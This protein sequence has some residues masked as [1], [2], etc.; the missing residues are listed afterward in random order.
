MKKLNVHIEERLLWK[1]FQF[2]GFGQTDVI[3]E[4]LD[5]TDYDTRQLS[6]IVWVFFNTIM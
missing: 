1:L 3:D 4:N 2:G 5:E 6:L